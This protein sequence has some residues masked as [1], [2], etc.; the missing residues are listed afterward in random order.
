MTSAKL[1]RRCLRCGLVTGA[2]AGSTTGAAI[3]LYEPDLGFALGGAL[4]GLLTGLVVS[5]VPTV[6]AGCLV[7]ALVRQRHP[8]PA[9]AGAVKRD[10]GALFCVIV[11]ILDVAFV[12]PVFA[13]GDGLRS[14]VRS[15][16]LLVVANASV[17]AMLWR[18]RT[19]IAQAWSEG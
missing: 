17:A 4:Y 2:V 13:L 10:L 5:L 3:G 16:P 6:I 19:S 12:V 15:L 1:Y 18:A 8:H 14:V 7:T 11:L 9:S